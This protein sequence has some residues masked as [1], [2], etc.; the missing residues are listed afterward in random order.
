MLVP[1]RLSNEHQPE[2]WSYLIRNRDHVARMPQ[3]IL[4]ASR[5]LQC[6]SAGGGMKMEN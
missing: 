5:Y 1:K 6:S 2:K 4:P 3:N